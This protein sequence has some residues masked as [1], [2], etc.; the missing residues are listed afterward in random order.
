MTKKIQ[1]IRVLA[2]TFILGCAGCN[3]IDKLAKLPLQG[4]LTS[5]DITIKPRHWTI[6]VSSPYTDDTALA[7]KFIFVRAFIVNRGEESL[8]LGCSRV[9]RERSKI[10]DTIKTLL[11]GGR[12]Q[13]YE[14]PLAGCGTSFVEV[15]ERSSSLNLRIEIEPVSS[16]TKNYPLTIYARWGHGIDL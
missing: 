16:L 7:D 1:L 15:P 10:S 4:Q 8:R 6:E 3:G 5:A 9:S 11:P 12:L 2:S 14:G 13:F